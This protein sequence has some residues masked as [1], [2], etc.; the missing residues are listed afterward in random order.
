MLRTGSCLAHRNPY[1]LLLEQIV[2]LYLAFASLLTLCQFPSQCPHL[3]HLNRLSLDCR[4]D[5]AFS[6]TMSFSLQI[7]TFPIERSFQTDLFKQ[8]S[9]LC[10][11]FCLFP[12]DAS[13]PDA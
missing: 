12:S 4:L 6:Q 8:V 10:N 1:Q 13:D 9:D 7:A 11:A 2:E 3:Q 5:R